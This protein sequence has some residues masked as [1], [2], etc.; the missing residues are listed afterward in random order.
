MDSGDV[1]IIAAA[2]GTIINK[3][4]GNF[5]RSCGMNN[6]NWNAVYV[7]HADGSVAWYGHM[8]NGSLTTKSVGQTVA[9]GEFLGK[10]GSSGNSSGPHMHLEVY[11]P[12]NHLNDPFAGPCNN[13]NVNSWWISQRPYMD[14][15][16][17]HIAT[18]FDPPVWNPCSQEDVKNERDY[19]T[20]TDT[21][22][23]MDY[24]R[25]LSLNDSCVITIFRPDNSVWSSW[26]WHNTWSTY[27]AAWVYWWMI[28]G[29]AEPDGQWKF[30]TDYMNQ[31][32]FHYFWLGPAGINSSNAKKNAACVYP[33]PNDG[34]FTVSLSDKDL[35]FS[36]GKIELKI[37]DVLGNIILK[38]EM[39]APGMVIDKSDLPAGIY[40]YSVVDAERNI[41]SGKIIVK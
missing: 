38:K 20:N 25:F 5:D 7:Q 28:A 8:K 2:A 18:N 40:F 14:A 1:E 29:S 15:A 30:Q 17:N 13:F 33:D 22:F 11:D 37:R 9:V 35:N 12:S 41:A 31:T 19:F 26:S 21:I 10:V 39:N 27:N 32:Y 16:I 34:N 23:L 3:S 6:N 24:F 4:D 36:S